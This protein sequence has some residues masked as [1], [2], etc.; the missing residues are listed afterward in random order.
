MTVIENS[1]LFA[2]KYCFF[3]KMVFGCQFQNKW[4]AV[5]TISFYLYL[6]V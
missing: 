6:I 3:D 4:E 1:N 5:N 2:A